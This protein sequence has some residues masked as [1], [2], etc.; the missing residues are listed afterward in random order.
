M[1]PNQLPPQP[2]QH[3]PLSHPSPTPTPPASLER[4]VHT[5]WLHSLCP[6][7]D[8][9][10]CPATLNLPDS[11]GDPALTS[12]GVSV[13]MTGHSSGQNA[14]DCHRRHSYDI[15]TSSPDRTLLPHLHTWTPHQT[16]QFPPP[17]A[18]RAKP[19]P[20]P[21]ATPQVLTGR[22]VSTQQPDWKADR[23]ATPSSAPSQPGPRPAA[24]P[25]APARGP[26]T[27]RL[28]CSKPSSET[29]VAFSLPHG[30]QAFVQTS[31]PWTSAVPLSAT[32][33]A[34]QHPLCPRTTEPRGAAPRL[35]SGPRPSTQDDAQRR[36][37]RRV[38]RLWRPS[39]QARRLLRQRGQAAAPP[40]AKQHTAAPRSLPV[41]FPGDRVPAHGP[42]RLRA[43]CTLCSHGFPPRHRRGLTSLNRVKQRLKISIMKGQLQSL[44]ISF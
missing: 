26:G 7:P 32:A 15:L 1:R 8:E 2:P 35:C 41:G 43:A 33:S 4:V 16:H 10:D 6:S 44:F 27:C 9:P 12:P 11:R 40:R 42:T 38:Q 30:R 5:R 18:H 36:A 31:P 22:L 37:G 29:P 13:S 21:R 24:A 3:T 23:L 25:P 14:A 19:P 28:L 39:Q 17:S 34:R 20:P